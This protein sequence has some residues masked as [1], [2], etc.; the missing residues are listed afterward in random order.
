VITLAA[1]RE[2]YIR[3]TV[4]IFIQRSEERFIGLEA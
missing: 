3:Q 1:R 4:E 2:K